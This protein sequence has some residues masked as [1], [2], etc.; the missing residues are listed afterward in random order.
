MAMSHAAGGAVAPGHARGALFEG[1][2]SGLIVFIWAVYA[3][4]MAYGAFGGAIEALS[5]DDA[6][7]LAEVNDLLAGQSW[8]DLTQYRLNP[9]DGVVMHWSRVIDLPIALILLAAERLFAQDV[10]L[11]LT[12]TLW[13]LLLL[14]PALFAVASASRTLAGPSA[15]VIGAFMLVMSPGVTQRFAPSAID[16]HGAQVALALTLLACALRI[17]TSARA[18][19][20]AGVCAALMTAIG[21][22]TAPHVAVCA[23]VIALRWAVTGDAMARGARLFGLTFAAGTSAVALATLSPDSWSAPV[24]DTLGVG[25]LAIAIVGGLGLA[26]A[27]SF[28]RG[29]VVSR[30]FGL[31]Q[32]GVASLA[33]L[34]IAS[35][36]CFSSPYA[37]L[38]ERLQT[39]WLARVQEAQT[40]VSSAINEPTASVAI[41]LPL[42]A[43][44]GVAIW[45]MATAKPEARWRVGVAVAM[46]AA[47]LGVTAWQV[48][49][50]SLAFAMAAPLLPMAVLAIGRTGDALRTVL[51]VIA[52]SPATL[53]LVGLGVADAA[54]LEPIAA[55]GA[56]K[57]CPSADYLA[58]GAL[59]L[60]LALNTIDTGPYI[61]ALSPLAAVAA[62]YH[63]NVD[64]LTAAIDA[65]QG[66]E[67]AAR[68]VAV[69]RN[70][71]YVV[72][73]PLDG[74]VTPEALAHPG[75]FSD[76]LVSGKAPAWLEPIPLGPHAKLLAFRVLAGR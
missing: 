7:R 37:A 50:V 68:A 34:A 71:T 74:G 57:R 24:C 41:G 62:P 9:P 23:A 61:L 10:A 59:P 76:I 32:V 33:A 11:R 19:V 27:T 12:L 14:L 6:A 55:G 56:A 8:F 1:A 63:R 73:C 40:F 29:D 43:V 25:H 45:A 65:F 44:L 36:N 30:F 21:M 39:G 64:G 75:G 28:A 49:G 69:S 2:G 67:E 38:P 52:L 48:R 31:A 66:S 47:A 22:E 16:H 35:P 3:F 18:A 17:E 46:F 70:A 20:G 51:A 60:G 4:A 13:P 42:L 58:L 72:V 53:A 26:A 5:T 15:G 54:G